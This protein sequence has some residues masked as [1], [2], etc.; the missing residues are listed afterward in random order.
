VGFFIA[1]LQN[2]GMMEE[3]AANFIRLLAKVAA[4]SSFS[5]NSSP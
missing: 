1:E 5:Q 2:G 3:S 4:P